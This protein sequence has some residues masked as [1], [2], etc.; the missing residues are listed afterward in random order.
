VL[1]LV[2][3]WFPLRFVGWFRLV[4]DSGHGASEAPARLNVS[5]GRNV[6]A[7]AT[8]LTVRLFLGLASLTSAKPV[9]GGG[10]SFVFRTLGGAILAL[11]L[12]SGKDF[13]EAPWLV[14]KALRVERDAACLL[15]FHA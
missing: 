3:F 7:T 14:I 15:G 8:P 1:L 9:F 12:R 5:V 6:T 11:T 10:L 13:Q 2:T 4:N